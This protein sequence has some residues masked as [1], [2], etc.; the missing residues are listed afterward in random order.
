MNRKKKSWERNTESFSPRLM[1]KMS[2]VTRERGE[3]LRENDKSLLKP[4]KKNGYY[5]KKMIKV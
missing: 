1:G 5:Y 3:N 2:Q 4:K